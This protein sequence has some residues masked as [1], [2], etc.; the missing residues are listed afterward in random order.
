[1]GLDLPTDSHEHLCG[2]VRV[3]QSREKNGVAC[4]AQ[5]TEENL[6]PGQKRGGDPSAVI[7]QP[8]TLHVSSKAPGWLPALLP[9]SILQTLVDAGLF[10]PFTHF[11]SL[12][13]LHYILA[14][15]SVRPFLSSI[16]SRK[17]LS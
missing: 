15:L 8:H 9:L 5:H 3:E 11:G 13:P 12:F 6:M 14:L 1:M 16:T 2:G 4:S 10:V 17:K 7:C